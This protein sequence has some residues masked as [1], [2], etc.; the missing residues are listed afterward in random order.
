MK[1]I[2][3]V[4][5]GLYL[6]SLPSHVPAFSCLYYISIALHCIFSHHTIQIVSLFSIGSLFTPI[7]ASTT[8]G[9]LVLLL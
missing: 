7:H 8:K 4:V 3:V 6:R 5:V 2:K 9:S 1:V